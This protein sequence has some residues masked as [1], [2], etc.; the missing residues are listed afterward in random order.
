MKEIMDEDLGFV[1]ENQ[2]VKANSKVSF[3]T[4]KL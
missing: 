4:K 2:A 3:F 1:V